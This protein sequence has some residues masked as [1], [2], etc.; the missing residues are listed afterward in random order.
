[1]IIHRY[2]SDLRDPNATDSWIVE[3]DGVLEEVFILF[4]KPRFKRPNDWPSVLLY[5]E[6]E[7]GEEFKLETLLK[8]FVKRRRYCI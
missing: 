5:L 2:P 1:M 7:P 6:P 8:E 3:N 4:T